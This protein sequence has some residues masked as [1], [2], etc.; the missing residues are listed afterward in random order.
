MR[1]VVSR[2]A[3]ARRSDLASAGLA[4]LNETL[5]TTSS[6][7][8]RLSSWRPL[9]VSQILT[10]LS[11]PPVAICRPSGL[12]YSTDG[13]RWITIEASTE[14]DG[15]YFWR[16][17]ADLQGTVKVRVG[18][19]Q[20]DT[21]SVKVGSFIGDHTKTSIGTLLNTGSVIGVMCNLMAGA[22]VLPKSIPSFVWYMQDRI[23]KGLGLGYALETARTA[24]SRRKVELTDAMADLIKHTEELT[25][26]EKMREVKKYRRKMR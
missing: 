16:L 3:E 19:A 5:V 25:R 2:L 9:A 15:V 7:P 13:R 26:E 23:S 18:D 6:C 12:K 24:M 20:V 14:N 1:M 17:P 21:G 4:A 10:V 22:S 8:V 11:K